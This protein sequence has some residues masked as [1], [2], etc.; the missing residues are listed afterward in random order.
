MENIFSQTILGQI[1]FLADLQ[2][3]YIISFILLGYSFEQLEINTSFKY[4]PKIK[5]RFK[6]A[7]L[8]LLYAPI[9]FLLWG[10]KKEQISGLFLS[11]LLTFSFHK[12][13]VD[14]FIGFIKRKLNAF[15][16]STGGQYE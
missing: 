6:V 12:L 11:Y 3:L 5:K 4:F 1:F 15:K 10:L 8:G 16:H 7:L 13:L 14:A 2:W 9:Y